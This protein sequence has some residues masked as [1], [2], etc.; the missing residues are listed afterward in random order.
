MDGSCLPSAISSSSVEQRDEVRL[1]GLG[2]LEQDRAAA[3][4]VDQLP[5]RVALL[6]GQA[7]EHERGVRRVQPVELR[8]ELDRVLARDQRLDQLLLA[9]L[10]ARDQLADD[11]LALH[12]RLDLAQRRLERRVLFGFV[13]QVRRQC[14]PSQPPADAFVPPS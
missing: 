11:L 3:L 9:G 10:L 14:T 13:A 7:L 12:H 4:L 6:G 2:Q 5:G 8:L 1:H